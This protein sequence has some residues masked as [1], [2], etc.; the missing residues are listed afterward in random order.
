[1]LPPRLQ[2]RLTQ[3]CLERHL[4]LVE[5]FVIDVESG[6]QAD[7]AIVRLLV[8]SLHNQVMEFGENIITKG[9]PVTGVIFIKEHSVTV[10]GILDSV[11][12]LDFHE[13]GF[14][15]EWEVIFDKNAE[16]SYVA[17]NAHEFP[18]ISTQYYFIKPHD[19]TSILNE[20][21]EF[22]KFQRTRAIR[23]RAYIRYLEQEVQDEIYNYHHKQAN[24]MFNDS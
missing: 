19:F 13:T 24:N 23:R 16:R 22:D 21:E 11:R 12:L 17:T 3:I 7:P 20:F 14:I 15:G 2:E 10:L 8:T 9:Q 5:H 18:S 6:Y 4:S 1:M